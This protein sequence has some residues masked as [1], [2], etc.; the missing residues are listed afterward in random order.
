MVS[1]LGSVSANRVTTGPGAR[2][3]LLFVWG[4]WAVMFLAL[5]GYVGA[6]SSPLPFV[7]D[8]DFIPQLTGNTDPSFAWLWEQVA[9]HRHLVSKASLVGLVG[10][11]R[12][13]FRSVVVFDALALGVVSFAAV[14]IAARQRGHLRYT[15]AFFP[16]L[17]L[18]WGLRNYLLLA[19]DGV[20]HLLPAVFALALLLIV[21]R[22]GTTLTVS[23]GLL[24]GL[25]LILL[26]LSNASGIV[27]A[28]ALALWLGA[29]GRR[30]GRGTDPG[31]TRAG[32]LVILAASIALLIVPLYFLDY[33]PSDYGMA[34]RPSLSAKLGVSLAFL[35]AG[36]GTTAW[37]GY[38]GTSVL[39]LL[40]FGCGILARAARG[41]PTADRSFARGL[42]CFVPPFSGLALAIGW[43]RE[44]M[45]VEHGLKYTALALPILC[46]VYYVWGL[47]RN[48]IG[49]SVQFGLFL[50]AALAAGSNIADGLSFGRQH[51]ALMDAF[52]RD[53][54]DE[55]S[56]FEL[57]PRY[58]E[59][60]QY[61]GT[62]DD[63]ARYLEQAKRAGMGSFR[64]LRDDPPFV[65]V[66][67]PVTPSA[68][69]GMDWNGRTASGPGPGAVVTFELP[70][71]TFLAGI[72]I[73]GSHS[74]FESAEFE[75]TYTT[76]RGPD[77][78]AETRQ[79][80]AA[81]P[82]STIGGPIGGEPR[83]FSV[84]IADTIKRFSIR[85]DTKSFEF[86]I[87]EIVLLIPRRGAA[88]LQL[89]DDGRRR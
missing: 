82:P 55:L 43:G 60:M 33:H 46:F 70:K 69:A 1:C 29:S 24:A 66:S 89:A 11:S 47:S 8:W 73:L 32:L 59:S 18:S 19:S 85:P 53:L 25:L 40:V 17:L 56:P 13:D 20:F 81:W 74:N 84:Y 71:P 3:A 16:L 51:R 78:A 31:A 34:T 10:A 48:W 49:T 15:D 50:C 9:Q 39:V 54:R 64:Q 63:M 42:L 2:G 57:I 5:L 45:G 26:E 83:P 58:K 38:V 80:L 6:F 27:Y 36:F 88:E 44:A 37:W 62:H 21:V 79:R 41:A 67:L 7:D 52:E 12:G 68:V 22:H 30:L 23:S 75:L 4:I 65:E 87:L 77:S 28:P 35:A 86:Q 61:W 14:R 76:L 72:R